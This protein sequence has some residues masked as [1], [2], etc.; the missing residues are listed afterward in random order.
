MAPGCTY[1]LVQDTPK[2]SLVKKLVTTAF[3]GKIM[4]AFILCL[5]SPI[6]WGP[7]GLVQLQKTSFVH[8]V[9]A[10][11]AENK[12]TRA[13]RAACKTDVRGGLVTPPSRLKS[14]LSDLLP[15][16]RRPIAQ[17][18]RLPYLPVFSLPLCLLPLCVCAVQGFVFGQAG[19]VQSGSFQTSLLI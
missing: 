11:F 17:I 8:Y 3:C 10:Q 18:E 5:L 7:A 13:E 6:V 16:Y 14:S 9:L 12:G 19:S 1:P 2:K 4:P 15:Q